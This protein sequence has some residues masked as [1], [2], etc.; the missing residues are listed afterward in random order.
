[1]DDITEEYSKGYLLSNNKEEWLRQYKALKNIE[2]AIKCPK[3]G[4]DRQIWRNQ[5]THKLTC[6]RVGCDNLELE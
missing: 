5:L 4:N 1:M 6:H 2:A 3:C